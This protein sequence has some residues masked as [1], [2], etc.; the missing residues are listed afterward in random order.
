MPK[1][2][3]IVLAL[4]ALAAGIFTQ[5]WLASRP[6][7]S[8]TMEIAFPD[9]NGKIHPLQQWKDQALIVNFWASWCAPC[10][11]EMPEF[12]KWQNELGPQGVQFVGVLIDD[13]PAMARKFLQ[14]L[15]VNYPIL[16]GAQGGRQWA[17]QLGD[18]AEVLPYSVIFDQGVMVY[19]KAGK[20]GRG[21]LLK[22]L[23]TR[24]D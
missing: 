12:V 8:A 19:R 23:S 18:K 3:S 11:E 15:P 14:T 21:E 13:D 17:T 6:V 5:R 1:A 9:L 20:L 10:V 7:D 4:V 16:D 22:S 2:L 24:P